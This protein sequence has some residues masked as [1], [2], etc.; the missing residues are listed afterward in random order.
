MASQSSLLLQMCLALRHTRFY[1]SIHRLSLSLSL[2]VYQ[3]ATLLLRVC[4]KVNGEQCRDSE[5]RL[6]RSLSPMETKTTHLQ[7]AECRLEQC[8]SRTFSSI[9][10]SASLLVTGGYKLVHALPDGDITIGTQSFRAKWNGQQ[11]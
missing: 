4:R 2:C 11:K 9:L 7:T 5:K 8:S 6:V 1:D 10:S 3:R